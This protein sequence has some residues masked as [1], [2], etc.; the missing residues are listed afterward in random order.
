MSELHP[1]GKGILDANYFRDRGKFGP[2][3][4]RDVAGA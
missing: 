3:S 1:G 2:C 4:G